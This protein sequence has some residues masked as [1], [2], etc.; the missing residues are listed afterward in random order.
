MEKELV[1]LLLRAD[2]KDIA[3]LIEDCARIDCLPV[4]TVE[5]DDDTF[6]MT[7]VDGARMRYRATPRPGLGSAWCSVMAGWM[8]GHL[9]TP[10][11][12]EY[13]DGICPICGQVEPWYIPY[14]LFWEIDE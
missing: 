12:D 8:C 13:G 5:I 4:E 14:E 7:R 10:E 6:V 9:G 11:L 1:S 2:N 3:R